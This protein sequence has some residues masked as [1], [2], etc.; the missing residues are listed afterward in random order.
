MSARCQKRGQYRA[1][2]AAS[3]QMLCIEGNADG[4]DYRKADNDYESGDVFHARYL[5]CG[6]GNPNTDVAPVKTIK[7]ASAIRCTLGHG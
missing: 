3:N 1:T 4:H 6:N 5:A 2:V 7:N